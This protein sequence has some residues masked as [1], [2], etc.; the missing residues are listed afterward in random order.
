MMQKKNI[1]FIKSKSFST[2]LFNILRDKICINMH[3][4]LGCIPSVVLISGKRNG[5]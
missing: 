3:E 4:A 2:H 1:N 5:G